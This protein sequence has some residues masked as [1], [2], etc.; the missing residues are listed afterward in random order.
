MTTAYEILGVP[1]GASQAAIREAYYGLARAH[2]P[3][4]GND[5]DTFS[6]IVGA[7]AELGNE[8]SRRLYDQR[9]ALV[10]A[11][12]RCEIC[13]GCG[14]TVKSLS[15]VAQEFSTCQSCNGLGFQRS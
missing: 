8:D 11:L 3:D 7:Y 1:L 2:H 4:L 9:L 10:G 5:A 6:A 15:F 12:K 14:E 13:G